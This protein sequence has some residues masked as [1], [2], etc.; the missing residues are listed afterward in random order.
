MC[1]A[2]FTKLILFWMIVWLPISGTL[3]S[4][5]PLSSMI[6]N[7]SSLTVQIDADSVEALDEP[8]KPCHGA[9]KKS[10]KA[11]A[12]SHC[13]LCHLT[14]ST[15]SNI[16]AMYLPHFT[17]NFANALFVDYPSFIPDLPN[18][19]PRFSLA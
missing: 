10:P 2:T 18:P 14:A 3:A 13:A 9:A 7:H 19:P 8:T 4:V 12:C 1:K 5:M 6:K 11:Q 16:P 17:R 15:A